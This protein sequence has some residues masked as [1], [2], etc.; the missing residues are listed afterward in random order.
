MSTE[1]I[2]IARKRGGEVEV[3]GPVDEFAAKILDRAGFTFR[4][5]LRGVWIRLHFDTGQE[6]ENQKATYAARMLSAAGYQVDLDPNLLPAAG[7]R[8]P[9]NWWPPR[10]GAAMTSQPAPNSTQRHRR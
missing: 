8:A 5:T 3:E 7:H 9:V 1:P 10:T 2:R 6:R 4:P